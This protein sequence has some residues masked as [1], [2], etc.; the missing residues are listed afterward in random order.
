MSK[1]GQ[2]RG[3]R[4]TLVIFILLLIGIVVVLALLAAVPP[5]SR[6]ALI[7]HL[8]IP[9][10]FLLHGG[11]YEIPDLVFSYYP[12]NL[13]LLYMG[14]LFL[15][16]DILAKYIHATFALATAFLLFRYLNKRI[17]TAYACLGALFFLSIPIIVKL[18]ITVYVDLGLIFFSTASILLLFHWLEKQQTR[19]L[20]LAGICCGLA[21]GT[22]YNGLLILFLLTLF[23]PLLSI[24]TTGATG[25]ATLGAAGSAILF[26]L[27]AL[28]AASPWLI[29][30]SIWT[31]NPIYPLYDSFFH[32]A[33]T[34]SAAPASTNSLRG[35]FAT[36]Y[37]LYGENIWQL[38][39]LP[40]RI[41][42][43]GMDN[44]PRYFD[45]RLNPFLLILPMFAFCCQAKKCRKQHLE[46]MTLLAF[47]LFYFLFAFHT[48]VL[49][50]RYLSPMIPCLVILSIYGL[51]N[52]EQKAS[53]LLPG[54][55]SG[56][57]AAW[58]LAGMLLL[59]NFT[60]IY[61]QFQII[62]PLPYISG[63]LN[64]NEYLRQHLPEYSVMEYANKHLSPSD[65]I[66]CLNM[67]WRGYYLRNTHIFDNEQNADLFFSWLQKPGM[68][69]NSVMKNLEKNR[70]SHL[71]I[72][73]DLFGQWLERNN[74]EGKKL[75]FNLTKNKITLLI[76]H[77]GFAL[78]QVQPDALPLPSQSE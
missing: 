73:I 53:Q 54:K 64:R 75:W 24:R 48:G 49:R 59:P 7:Q 74:G 28:L 17:S 70:I 12:M 77:Q 66:L 25:R 62:D 47:A 41:F 56:E 43:Q 4:I 52:L 23:I 67:G 40:V 8:Q 58:L 60:Y 71:L 32:P 45:G 22:K 51:R 37:F 19:Y 3:T 5:T 16:S 63:R 33:V 35:V 39:L 50:I 69:V 10:L 61:Q 2:S 36:R 1:N 27:C 72:R 9:K 13:D 42:F 21:L 65:K 15:G 6:D 20:L 14:A 18:S 55:N 46:K 38:L 44:D 76:S 68:T 57:L 11:I 34:S 78:Y 30:N 31:G 29:R 26:L